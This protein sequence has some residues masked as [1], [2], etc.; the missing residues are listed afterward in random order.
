MNAATGLPGW[1]ETPEIALACATLKRAA[2]FGFPLFQTLC[3]AFSA[4]LPFDSEAFEFGVFAAA[5]FGLCGVATFS[6]V[7]NLSGCPWAG[8]AASVAFMLRFSG[9]SFFAALSP[10]SWSFFLLFIIVALLVEFVL[11]GDRRVFIALVFVCGLAA[12]HSGATLL[13]SVCALGVAI[14]GDRKY[15][16]APL[17]WA[18]IAFVL[19]A[20]SAAM[21]FV[22]M[23]P[24]L[25]INFTS[26]LPPWLGMFAPGENAVSRILNFGGLRDIVSGFLALSRIFAGPF[27]AFAVCWLATVFFSRRPAPAKYIYF[28]PIPFA[29]MLMLTKPENREFYTEFLFFLLLALGAAGIHDAFG[30]AGSS[31][32]A[33]P[34][35]LL[36]LLAGLVP[37]LYLNFGPAVKQNFFP[38]EQMARELLKTSNRDETLFSGDETASYTEIYRSAERRKMRRDI[39]WR[40]RTV[41][42]PLFERRSEASGEYFSAMLK[43][44]RRDTLLVAD[45]EPDKLNAL[46]YYRE[47]RG[48]RKDVE[49]IFTKWL[50]RKDYRAYIWN[51]E[52]IDARVPDREE[53]AK[54]IGQIAKMA[55]PVGGSGS[56]SESVRQR[57]TSGVADLLNEAI[58]VQNSLRRP[59]CYN[60]IDNII[61]SQ[62]Y[63]V[64][65]FEPEGFLF[66]L[67]I[68]QPELFEYER[69]LKMATSGATADPTGREIT[70]TYFK[71]IGEHFY[72]QEKAA[73]AIPLLEACLAL[74]RNDISCNFFLGLIYKSWGRYQD[75]EKTLTKALE[76]LGKKKFATGQDSGDIFMMARIYKELGK[77]DLAEKYEKMVQ[78]TG[79]VASPSA[80]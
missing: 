48:L 59:V 52:Q 7:K 26:A 60:R 63:S 79:A 29:L 80:Q 9:M 28:A 32:K 67:L 57:I 53:Y 58:V 72:S 17:P 6:V 20:S 1:G 13:L 77:E 10:A 35:P 3:S 21:I 15:L 5:L 40:G 36:I 33:S 18:P 70:A 12:F 4:A 31:K 68:Y 64:M 54:M 56:L 50:L 45:P 11:C 8:V 49:V 47:T 46:T 44:M 25:I 16:S 51:N 19:L 30:D 38:R 41:V 61:N 39:L 23:R 76:L 75:A 34:V 27:F 66:R 65:Y 42:P 69:F 14:F 71:N 55:R 43:S 24:P 2:F 22:A 73:S 78:P 62:M 74:N 37:P